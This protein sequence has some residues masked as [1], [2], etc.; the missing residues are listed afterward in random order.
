[1][2]RAF[3]NSRIPNTVA[4]LT[5]AVGKDAPWAQMKVLFIW[6]LVVV[7]FSIGLRII[8]IY[9][10]NKTSVAID[11]DLSTML[12][13]YTIN[14][15]GSY[16][17]GISTIKFSINSNNLL[18]LS[19]AWSKFNRIAY[20]FMELSFCLFNL[21]LYGNTYTNVASAIF[22]VIYV[23]FF[24]YTVPVNQKLTEFSIKSWNNLCRFINS[25]FDYLNT[26][27]LF[28][29]TNDN[30]RE[31][32]SHLKENNNKRNE[33][34]M[35]K[36]FIISFVDISFTLYQYTVLFLIILAIYQKKITC[37]FLT[38][39]SILVYRVY[40]NLKELIGE[41]KI[42]EDVSVTVESM[43]N[44]FFATSFSMESYNPNLPT[45]SVQD[46]DIVIKNLKF[47]GNNHYNDEYIL[48]VK[49]LTF[50]GGEKY[51]I[52]GRSGCGKTSLVNLLVNFWD[53]TGNIFLGQ[54]IL[55]NYNTRDIRRYISLTSQET[56]ILPIGVMENISY[57][58]PDASMAEVE[59]AAKKACIHDFI[60]TLPQGYK[61]ILNDEVNLSGGQKQ[62]II[63]ARMFLS[64]APIVILDE[65]TSS[66]DVKTEAIIYNNIKKHLKEKTVIII[67]HRLG[68]LNYF[69]NIILM[70]KG[71][72]ILEDK[73]EAAKKHATFINF[74]DTFEQEK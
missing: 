58:N 3:V 1:M 37:G 38:L 73:Y 34:L 16:R 41:Y 56:S 11:K 42:I 60:V 25:S 4:K 39:F 17:N 22:I 24:F 59:F 14:Q 61:T 67:A 44:L 5:E 6:S 74:I 57:G 23:F 62:K 45:L 65:S 71:K 46:M 32:Q 47:Q 72:V 52:M 43:K 64:R 63:L 7:L 10:D 19:K 12:Y 33:M 35:M 51:I 20:L 2:F 53:Y 50:K 69:D 48:N 40:H 18:R 70:D 55:K 13:L 30:I 54:E 8:S 29:R 21:I 49:N 31:F 68:V 15:D 26:I 28:N 66:L 9:T 27:H 36:T